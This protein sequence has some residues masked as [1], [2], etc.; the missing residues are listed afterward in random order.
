[1]ATK[2]LASRKFWIISLIIYGLTVLISA[3]F[4]YSF[5]LILVV[6]AKA[7]G[8]PYSIS[9]RLAIPLVILAING[10]LFLG[11][12]MQETFKSS[13]FKIT[14]S[15]LLKLMG[16]IYCI[17]FIYYMSKASFPIFM[18]ISGPIIHASAILVYSMRFY[19]FLGWER[20]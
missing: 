10:V 19:N 13:N 17:S 15:L 3:L 6:W 12:I 2:F 16:V 7:E 1:M 11:L 18:E 14:A 9:V 8:N 20:D 4:E 5:F